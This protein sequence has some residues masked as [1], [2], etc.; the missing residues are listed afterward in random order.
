MAGIQ[1]GRTESDQI[2]FGAGHIY[3]P[4]NLNGLTL[5]G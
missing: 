2:H 3:T 5:G 4:D 1:I